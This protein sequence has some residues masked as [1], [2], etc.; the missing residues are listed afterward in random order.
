MDGWKNGWIEKLDEINVFHHVLDSS[1]TCIQRL[2]LPS[3]PSIATP[4]ILSTIYQF[5]KLG[6]TLQYEKCCTVGAFSKA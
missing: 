2:Q 5:L 3:S 1:W 6:F 4:S